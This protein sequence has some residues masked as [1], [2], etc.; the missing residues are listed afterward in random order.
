MGGDL[1]HNAGTGSAWLYALEDIMN[2][3]QEHMCVLAF[4]PEEAFSSS[5]GR[6][7]MERRREGEEIIT[8]PPQVE[9]GVVSSQ[10]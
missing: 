7:A 9:R 5:G 4:L 3:K 1:I 8:Q 2:H 6:S 10:P